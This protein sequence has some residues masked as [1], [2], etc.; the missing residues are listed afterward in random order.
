MKTTAS[1]QE[2]GWVL[3][4]RGII[5]DAGSGTSISHSL[6]AD[7]ELI[8]AQGAFLIPGLIDTHVH[9]REPGL[10]HKGTILSESR[11]AAAGG[12]VRVF[13]MPNTNPATTTAELVQAKEA[14]A[15]H[16][17]L[18]KYSALMGIVPGNNNQIQLLDHP[19]AVKLFL[20]TST[21]AMGAPK[22]A[23]LEETFRI[24]A[25]LN[26]PIIV[27]AEDNDIID[28]NTA[29]IVANC[30]GDPAKVDA[31]HYHSIIRSRQACLKASAQAV[32]LAHRFGTRLHIAHI[33]TAE[34]VRELLQSGP[35][36]DK[37][38]TAET[39]PLYIDPV[40]SKEENRTIRHKVNPAI[41]TENDAQALLDAIN[42][43]T[44][45]TIGS[46]HAPH[47]LAD[48]EQPGLKAASGAPS[49]Q[50]GLPIMMTYLPLTTIVSKMVDGPAQV[51][52]IPANTR[53]T[54]GSPADMALVAPI[55]PHTITDADV[56]TPCAWTPF[57]GRTIAHQV[58][59]TW[60]DGIRIR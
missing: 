41:K 5:I 52:R 47:L 32:E 22:A 55:A 2:T 43:G 49:I 46:D 15:A 60:R 37:L 38:V 35:T 29:D 26:I 10:T 6:P 13:D 18:L 9:F 42:N 24:C 31:V 21:G 45:D 8:D 54:I 14:I 11:A 44:I 20:G 28:R 58:I 16:A 51:F 12:V 36:A 56:I 25:Q 48:K 50:F 40:I 30:G 7:A 19:Y 17:G 59:S 57:A 33:S 53:F 39:T 34:E 23:E 27:H 4:D 1:G 3:F